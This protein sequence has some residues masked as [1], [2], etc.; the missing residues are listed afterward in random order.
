MYKEEKSSTFA[1]EN[2]KNLNL[3]A[4]TMKK[5]SFIFTLAF[6]AMMS[7]SFTSCDEDTQIA[8]EL[9][10][11]WRGNVGTASNEY[12]IDIRFYQS[13]F[14]THGTGYEFLESYYSGREKYTKFNWSVRNG[15]I[16]IDYS[17]GTHVVIED[18]YLRYNTLSGRLKEK[19]NGWTANSGLITLT[20]ISDNP[21]DDGYHY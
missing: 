2:V 1:P 17:D 4:T 6:I 15:C 18:Y 12:F 19:R 9:D 7:F 20:R 11:T 21:Y 5:L 14:S 16:Y 3:S 8:I 10:G 13:G